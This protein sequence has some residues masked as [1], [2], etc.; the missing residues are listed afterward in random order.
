MSW[1]VRIRRIPGA[2]RIDTELVE[3]YEKLAKEWEL[4]QDEL[5]IIYRELEGDERDWQG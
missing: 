2:K 1:S 5:E 4:M 3:R